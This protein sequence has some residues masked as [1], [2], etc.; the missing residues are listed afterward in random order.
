MERFD[1]R[2]R[3]PTSPPIS[4]TYINYKLLLLNLKEIN[5]PLFKD[6]L[7]DTGDKCPLATGCKHTVCEVAGKPDQRLSHG[8]SCAL[9]RTYRFTPKGRK[10]YKKYKETL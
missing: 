3:C 7:L 9:A 1:T 4:F 5:M 10:E 8:Y 2:E 6:G